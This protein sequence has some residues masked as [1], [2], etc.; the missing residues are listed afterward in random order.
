MIQFDEYG[1]L[2]PYEVI[3]ISL[4]E[5]EEEFVSKLAEKEHRTEI[6]RAYLEYLNELFEV[7]GRDFFQLING[8]FTTAKELPKD[9]DLATFVD[10]RVYQQK[11]EDI[12]ELTERW[13]LNNKI[14]CYL[15]PISYPGHPNFIETQLTF[16]YWKNLFSL[17]RRTTPNRQKGLIKITFTNE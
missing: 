14:D 4:G 17:S 10:Y 9:I 2:K 7:V 11:F 3:E 8:S 5:F 12:T 15:L 1:N 13:T 16:E 6:F